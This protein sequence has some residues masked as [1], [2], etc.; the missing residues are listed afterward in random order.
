[1]H[2]I[3]GLGN[4]TKQYENTRHNIGFMAIDALADKYDINMIECKHKSL[5]G[6]GMING[7]KVILVKPLTYMNLSGEAIRAVS[8]YY[9][10]DETEELLVIYDDI[11]LDIGQIRIRKKGSAG[12]HN[13][14]KSI[15]ANL[16]HDTFR[17]IKIGVGGKPEGYDLADYVL[18][19]FNGEEIAVM[20]DSLERTQRAVNLILEGKVDAAMNEYNTKNRCKDMEENQK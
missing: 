12:G 16:G 20:K 6:K 18:G 19:H 2:I 17:R 1:M 11:S 4:P 5:I 14:L 7:T 3:A 13:G 8:E 9:K 15:I 10:I